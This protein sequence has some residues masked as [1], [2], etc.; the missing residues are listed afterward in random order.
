MSI[1]LTYLFYP[2]REKPLILD[3]EVR[4][5]FFVYGIVIL[6]SINWFRLIKD[7]GF[8][9]PLQKILGGTKAK[10]NYSE[11]DERYMQKMAMINH[12]I[13]KSEKIRNIQDY[14]NVEKFYKN[15]SEYQKYYTMIHPPDTVGQMYYS[16]ESEVADAASN[17]SSRFPTTS[18]I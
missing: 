8:I 2:W 13:R 7:N 3:K 5:L 15:N 10:K 1:L 16:K 9:L 6:L 14:P 18:S 4:V 17:F 11:E 12:N